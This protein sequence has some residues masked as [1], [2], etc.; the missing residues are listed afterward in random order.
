MLIGDEKKLD[1][2]CNGLELIQSPSGYCFTTD[3][4]LL[5]A[6]VKANAKERVVELGSG[7]G[8]ISILL[9]EKTTAKEIV[10]LE[11]QKRLFDMS[12][13]SLLLNNIGSRVKFINEDIKKASDILG[14][15]SFD[16]V[17]TNPPYEKFLLERKAEERDIAK[18]EVLITLEEIIKQSALLL[19]NGGRF[20]L[21]IKSSRMGEVFHYMGK[22]NVTPKKIIPVQS[23][24]TDSIDLCLVEG[25]KQGAHGLII[26]RPLILLDEN[27]NNT[28]EVTAIYN[29]QANL[30]NR[31]S[32]N[33]NE[34]R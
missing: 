28:K 20:Y 27:G 3:A 17:V 11:I 22:Y 21:V 9:F 25:K 4:V 34:L 24:N 15:G 13:R 18:F 5:A 29:N 8:V 10:G 7:S 32:F 26:D 12:V 19:K 33:S 23:K 31:E 1:L 6:L 2:Q 14:I 16:V 30:Y